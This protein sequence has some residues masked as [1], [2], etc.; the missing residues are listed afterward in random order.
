MNAERG[1][2]MAYKRKWEC[3]PMDVAEVQGLL[4][5]CGARSPSGIRNRALVAIGFGAALRVSESLALLPRHVDTNAGT[6]YV[7]QGKGGKSRYAGFNGSCAGYIDAWLAVRAKLDIP[8]DAPLFC[9]ITRGRVGRPLSR[10]Y[11]AAMMKQLAAR[12]GIDKRV[13]YHLLRHSS[14]TQMIGSGCSVEQVRQHLGHENVVTT[15][16]YIAQLSNGAGIEAA[17]GFQW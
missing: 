3:Q 15:A 14:A 2:D 4:A 7:H 13:Y 10:A 9:Q 8:T 17:R 12:A 5:A 1:H 16:A 11:V 6:A